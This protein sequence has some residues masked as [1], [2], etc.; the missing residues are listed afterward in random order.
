MKCVRHL[1]VKDLTYGYDHRD[2][3]ERGRGRTP[4]AD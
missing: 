3:A 1:E 4:D 2:R